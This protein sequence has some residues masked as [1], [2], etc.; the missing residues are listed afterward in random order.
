VG[1]ELALS[2]DVKLADSLEFRSVFSS[3]L[4]LLRER[5]RTIEEDFQSPWGDEF[6]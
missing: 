1:L 2:S 3:R 6:D 5:Q 4:P